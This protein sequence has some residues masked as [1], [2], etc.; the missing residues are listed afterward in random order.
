[1]GNATAIADIGRD[2]RKMNALVTMVDIWRTLEKISKDNKLTEK[3]E[4]SH[5]GEIGTSIALAMYPNNTIMAKA[6]KAINEY[7]VS[8]NIKP[9]NTIGLARFKGKNIY[10]YVSAKEI[11]TSGLLG[12]P[13][14]GTK[15]KGRILIKAMV[16]YLEKVITELQY[17]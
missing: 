5:G 10:T 14:K 2:F 1:M 9:V 7:P 12:D 16:L 4:L 15:E 3:S 6:Q 11:T 8:K 17:S 13:S